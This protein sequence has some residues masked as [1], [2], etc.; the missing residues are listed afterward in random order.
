MNS[1]D[2]T[3]SHRG[4]IAAAAAKHCAVELTPSLVP[5]PCWEG[6]VGELAEFYY[7]CSLL[8]M[9]LNLFHS[10]YAYCLD[11]LLAKLILSLGEH[12]KEEMICKVE[13]FKN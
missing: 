12:M 9:S 6:N 1:W 4:T 8:L 10:Y 3:W 7:I 5:G 13:L 2:Y 11:I